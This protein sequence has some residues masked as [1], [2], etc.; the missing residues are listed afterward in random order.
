[1]ISNLMMPDFPINKRIRLAQWIFFF[2]A[3]PLPCWL[4]Q[5]RKAKLRQPT[6]QRRSNVSQNNLGFMVLIL[7]YIVANSVNNVRF[8][9]NL[10]V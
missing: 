8:E 2:I 6:G 7:M 3:K 4:S 1:M 10:P 5:F 9:A